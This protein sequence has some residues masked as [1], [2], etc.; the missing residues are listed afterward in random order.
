MVGPKKKTYFFCVSP[1]IHSLYHVL[2]NSCQGVLINA[3]YTFIFYFRTCLDTD[4]FCDGQVDCT[5]GSDE[6]WCDPDSDPNAAPICDYA[7]C[8][9]PDCFCST[10]GTKIPGDLQPNDVPQAHDEKIKQLDQNLY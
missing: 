3:L 6:G 10:D 2:I 5:D 8:T 4:L 9:L 1:L 7:N